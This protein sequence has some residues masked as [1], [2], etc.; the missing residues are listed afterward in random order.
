MSAN[1][2]VAPQ[3]LFD[4]IGGEAAVGAAVD[5]F[6]QKVLKDPLLIPFFEGKDMAKQNAKLN[7]FMTAAFGG[8][9]KYSGKTMTAAHAE[10]VKNGL[11][12]EHFDRVAWHLQTTLGDLKVPQGIVEEVMGVVGTTRE[13]VLGRAE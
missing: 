8:P 5:L 7:M 2:D 3:P 6:Y 1:L 11:A 9:V 10:A 13:A 4:R 12:D